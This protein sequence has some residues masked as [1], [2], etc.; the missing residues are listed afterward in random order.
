MATLVL[1]AAGQAVGGF[2]G[3]VGAI[4]GRAAG[5]LAGNII[6]QRLFGD[7]ATREFGRISD[8]TV[9]TAAE[10][11][12]LP[13]V[14][15]RVR[16]AGTVIWATPFEENATTHSAG[17]GGG[18]KVR[19]YTYTASF[20]V[21]L[22][23]GQIARV[24]RVW[25]DGEPLDTEA[26]S[27][28][29]HTGAHDQDAD[30]LI[31]AVEGDAPA[32]RGTAY[33][34]FE[35]LPVGPYG[36]RLPQL[37]FEV[38]RPV[39][40]VER[41]VRAV[42]LIPGATEFGFDPVE[43]K[44]I[45]GPGEA[46]S[47]NRH[48]FCAA[49]D[50][51]AS[52]DE[53]QALCPNL[54]RV[55][56]VVSWFGT[57]LRAGACRLEPRVESR[58]REMSRPWAVAGEDRGSA[59][60]VSTDAEGRPAYGGT[61]SD[62]SV[63]AAIAAIRARGLKVVFYPF[64]LMDVPPGNHLEDP[65]GSTEQAAFPWRGRITVSPAPGRDGS[66]DG[67]G[68]ADEAVASFVGAAAPEH[69][70][71]ETDRVVYTGPAE[72]SFRRMMLH[73]AHLTVAAGG[74]DAFLVG[75]ELRG[76]TGVRGGEGYPFVAALCDVV[77]DVR[78]VVGAGVKLS[79]A[80]DWSEY[81]GHQP[82]NGDAVFHLD[83]L[84]SND[85]V[86]FIGIDNYW[87][88]AD[89]REGSHLDAALAGAITD[90]H[91]LTANIAG[92]EYYDWYYASEA[93]RLAQSRTPITDGA[94]GEPWIYR[95]KDL[96][97]WWSRPHHDR[98]AGVRQSIVA[99]ASAPDGWTPVA[100]A[101]LMAEPGT[102]LGRFTRAARVTSGGAAFARAGFEFAAEA[103]TTYEVRAWVKAGTSA[104]VLL[105]LDHSDGWVDVRATLAD[106]VFTHVTQTG[107]NTVSGQTLTHLGEDV[108][109][110]FL[111]VTTDGADATS[112]VRV[113][114][115]S[116]TAGD[117]IVVVAAELHVKGRST[118]GW[119]PGSKP[120]WFTEFGCPAVDKGAN[121]PNVFYDPKSAE[122]ALPHFSTGR[123]DDGMQRAYL[124]AML[125]A[126]DPARSSD[127]DR[128]NPVGPDGLARMVDPATM[129]V[130]TW[131]ARPWPAF[132]HLVDVWSDGANWER[133]HWLTGR[134]GAL[135]VKDLLAALFTE[136]S[137]APPRVEG[138]ATVVDGFV[139]PGPS[140]LR[141]VLEPLVAITC[142]VAA[143]TGREIRFLAP[144][145]PSAARLVADDLVEVDEGTPLVSETRE[146]AASLPVEM[147]LRYF[148]TGRDYQVA[149][150][151]YRPPAGSARQVEQIAA[152]VTM[153]D[154]L[155]AELA[156]IALALRWTMRTSVRFA[157]PLS[158]LDLL[159][160]DVVTLD[161]AGRRRDLVI[162]EIVDH[163]Y[164]EVSGRTLDASVLAPTP[165]P[166]SPSPPPVP[167]TLA[168]PV[169]FAMNLPLIDDTVAQHLPWIGV[170]AR[171]FREMG[172]WR[173]VPG[174]SFQLIRTLDRPAALGETVSALPPGPTSR[175]HYAGRVDVRFYNAA[176][177][178][179]DPLDVLSGVNGLAART[180]SGLWEVLQFRDAE[181]IGE[182]T[183]RLSVLLRGQLGTEDATALG[184][185][186]G[187]PVVLLNGTAAP[188]PTPREEIGLQRT[189]RIGPVVE[190]IGG[191]NV[192][193]FD[194]TPTARG[195]RP[196]APVHGE[197]RLR[198]SDGALL[199][200]WIRRTRK[201]GDV[202]PDGGTV[203]LSEA[204]ETYRLEILDAGAPVR[205]V[206]I[207][208]PSYVYL[209]DEQLADFGAPQTTLTFRVAQ[210][211]PDF[212]AGVL[213]EV[214]VDVKQP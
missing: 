106:G 171:P 130:W 131:D 135:P 20:A 81:F 102:F 22:C 40:E 100:Q 124:A 212:G 38:I 213:H 26:I 76:L 140:S 90:S 2:L 30:P 15:G 123:R 10:G 178:S 41:Q 13:R 166:G 191:L 50:M 152:P 193:T 167:P 46:L 170:H 59:A 133:G 95:P 78:S 94:Y 142:V 207:A 144:G 186:V 6:D 153:S 70:S 208:Q 39:G 164:R 109:Q 27:M 195:S 49:S 137:L 85:D 66:P 183:Y 163:D 54:E 107:T 198:P 67:T 199:V 7:S 62:A 52:L 116:A 33:V 145:Q 147:R 184:L 202:W 149:N 42:T 162:E 117:D 24:G 80:A 28:R 63:V 96:A 105:T 89:W 185:P 12:P 17:K 173:A 86:D 148:D 174:G 72:W 201:G 146:E 141:Q 18:P 205:A 181:L 21:A 190:G 82:G 4:V 160:G 161:L 111:E 203:P 168:P 45:V 55:A 177:S 112:Y 118:T 37:T 154:G 196:Y 104:R 84:W 157:L 158:R 156:E 139:V 9:Q 48:L 127:I 16:L 194:F 132:P 31:E 172:V 159:P 189:F 69:F 43:V 57:D 138:V 155:A 150:A 136:W 180:A 101:S 75:S 74:V 192:T 188:L 128:F 29:V 103:A 64:I 60:L 25:A 53:L 56:L 126:Y 121:Q 125:A 204:A 88:L 99:A 122:S 68:A 92:G 47:D 197:A 91:Y 83:P 143:D 58:E 120:V 175:W 187:A 108:Y 1:Q 93:D 14:Y 77:G 176:V 5:A 61:P 71:I 3:P 79:Y 169:A 129:H 87:P 35:H 23:E 211:S 73:Y 209:L 32:Y 51:E 115:Y 8:L 119:V 200:R 110:L 97:T 114:P 165:V 206:E 134:L 19:E 44:R 98:I 151:H 65:Y 34:V 214:T 182:R 36:N 11:N 210:I 179:Q 113:G